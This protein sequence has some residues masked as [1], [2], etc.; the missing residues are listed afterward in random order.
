L[1]KLASDYIYLNFILVALL[2]LYSML[3]NN[4]P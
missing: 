2:I 4:R 3:G 1:I